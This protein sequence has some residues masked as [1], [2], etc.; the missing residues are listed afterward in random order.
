VRKRLALIV[1]ALGLA[2]GA[3]DVV[4]SWIHNPIPEPGGQMGITTGYR[5]WWD[6]SPRS[7]IVAW[8]PYTHVL[9]AGYTN[10]LIVSNVYAKPPGIRAYFTVTAYGAT[11]DESDFGNEPSLEVSAPPP[12]AGTNLPTGLRSFTTTQ[13]QP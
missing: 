2:A 3:T 4:V 5:V 1:V 8:P 11:G 12:P 6:T 13:T 10:S 9:D 7:N